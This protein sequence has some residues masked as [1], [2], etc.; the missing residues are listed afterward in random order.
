MPE[1][2]KVSDFIDG[3]T[4]PSLSAGITCILSEEKY[5]DSFEATQQFLGTLVAN[6]AVHN[7]G[8]RGDDR[9]VSSTKG[10]KSG[11]GNKAKKGKSGKKLEARFYPR[12]EWEA[13]TQEERVKVLEL[14][15]KKRESKSGGGASK[16]KA[17]SAETNRDDD[18]GGSEGDH[19]GAERGDTGNSTPRDN[20]GDEFGRGAHKKRKV[21]S[22]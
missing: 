11:G 18:A 17:A 3:I 20:G 2:K 4:D 8:K 16:R 13:L 7:K 9:N 14:K 10:T 19:A 22:A 21:S 15:K 1:S 5:S 6:Q 12:D